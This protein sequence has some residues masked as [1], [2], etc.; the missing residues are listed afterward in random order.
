MA[1]VKVKRIGMNFADVKKALRVQPK[2]VAH[3][4]ASRVAPDLTRMAQTSYDAGQTAYGR[5]RPTGAGGKA[6]GLVD[7]GLTRSEMRF[8]AIGTVMRC[9]LGTP[10]ARYL[11]GKYAVLPNGGASIPIQWMRQIRA[12]TDEQLRAL[13]ARRKVA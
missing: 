9:V 6:L 7:S 8:D 3:S 1:R 4:I 10:W 5:P 11:I 12:V 13:G 2:T